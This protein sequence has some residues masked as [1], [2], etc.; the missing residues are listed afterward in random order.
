MTSRWLV[1]RVFLPSMC[2]KSITPFVLH[3]LFSPI[4]T[5]VPSGSVAQKRE[6]KRPKCSEPSS[7]TQKL[8]SKER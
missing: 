7:L 5:A 1:A 4:G 6:S 2:V 8:Y 3:A